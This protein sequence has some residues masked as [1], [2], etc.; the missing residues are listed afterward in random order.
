MGTPRSRSEPKPQIGGVGRADPLPADDR[1]ERAER[2]A[3]EEHEA[4]LGQEAGDEGVPDGQH[5]R[6]TCASGTDPMATALRRSA[7]TMTRRRSRRSES[8]PESR[9]SSRYGRPST[10]VTRAVSE[11]LPLSR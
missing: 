2:R 11:G 7:T 9:P 10:R 1:R 5:P 6:A 4:R 8:A 3:V